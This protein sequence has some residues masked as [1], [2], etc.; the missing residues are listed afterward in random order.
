MLRVWL[1]G[2]YSVAFASHNVVEGIVV[3]HQEKH[4]V[5]GNKIPLTAQYFLKQF[6]TRWPATVV[7]AG[8][9]VRHVVTK[10][11]L[12]CGVLIYFSEHDDYLTSNR[13]LIPLKYRA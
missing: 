12:L 13:K 8:N 1:T 5:D 2:A 7:V 4:V 11:G 10:V 9:G 3:L 6:Q